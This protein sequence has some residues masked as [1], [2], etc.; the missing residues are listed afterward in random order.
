MFKT[1]LVSEKIKEKATRELIGVTQVAIANY[2]NT[3]SSVIIN[4][5]KEVLPA[6]DST[7]NIPVAPI[8]ISNFGNEFDLDIVF[9]SNN[10]NT[11]LRFFRKIPTTNQKC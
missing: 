11:L 5:Q 2:S 8:E 7:Y 10:T 9:D 1:E 6:I 4:G 3:E